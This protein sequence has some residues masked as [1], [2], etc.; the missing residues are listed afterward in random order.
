M[1]EIGAIFGVFVRFVAQGGG[2]EAVA[3]LLVGLDSG[4]SLHFVLEIVLGLGEG[5]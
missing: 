3:G 4:F 2:A 5:V 1:V